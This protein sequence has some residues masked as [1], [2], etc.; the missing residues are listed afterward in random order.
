[1]SLFGKKT[2]TYHVYMSIN[3]VLDPKVRKDFEPEKFF[4]NYRGKTNHVQPDGFERLMRVK[5]H[6]IIKSKVRLD[7]EERGGERKNWGVYVDHA[8][9][10]VPK[11]EVY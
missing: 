2:P 1:M 9:N 6:N 10:P 7:F 4:H 11:K 3:P 5:G 8:L